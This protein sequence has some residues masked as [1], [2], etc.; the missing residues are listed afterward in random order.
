MPISALNLLWL[1]D[2]HDLQGIPAWTL[3]LDMSLHGTYLLSCDVA[4]YWEGYNP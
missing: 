4:P 3:L 2:S 1:S